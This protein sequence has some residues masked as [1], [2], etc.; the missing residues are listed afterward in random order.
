LRGR[1]YDV[2]ITDAEDYDLY[3]EVVS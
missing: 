2:M 3:A 1:F